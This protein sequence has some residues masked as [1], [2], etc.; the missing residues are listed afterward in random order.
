VLQQVLEQFGQEDPDTE[1]AE[2]DA[3]KD[4]EDRDRDREGDPE[5]KGE[6][7]GVAVVVALDCS[8]SSPASEKLTDRMAR[9]K[10]I[11]SESK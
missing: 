10:N 7:E 5:S 2:K 4:R 8:R 1:S 6:G 3:E 11:R 9:R